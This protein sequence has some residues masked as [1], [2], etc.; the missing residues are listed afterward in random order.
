M[1]LS[2]RNP[3]AISGESPDSNP[4]EK[5]EVRVPKYR[6]HKKI[7]ARVV[8]GGREVYLGLYGTPES[9]A[10]YEREVA[11]CLQSGR[12]TPKLKRR[13]ASIDSGQPSM[14]EI[15]VKYV[16]FADEYYTPHANQ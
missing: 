13:T 8:L 7:Y 11:E 14:T 15:I 6:R 4:A 12:K 10:N 9:N 2:D 5:F 3:A 16:E 1:A